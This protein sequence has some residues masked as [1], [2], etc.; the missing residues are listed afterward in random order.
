MY[1]FK[2]SKAQITDLFVLKFG[3]IMENAITITS[4]I[5]PKNP[6]V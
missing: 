2:A 6:H 3:K 4:T 5:I 1:T